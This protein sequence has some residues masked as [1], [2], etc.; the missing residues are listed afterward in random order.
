MSVLIPPVER[1]RTILW[2]MV[3]ES[4]SAHL[5][6][7]I[8]AKY[9][10]RTARTQRCA[11]TL[12]PFTRNVMSLCCPRSCILQT[13][14]TIWQTCAFS[15]DIHRAVFSQIK[16]CKARQVLHLSER[17]LIFRIGD[18]CSDLTCD[19]SSMQIQPQ[20]T[21][22]TLHKMLCLETRFQKSKPNTTRG[23]SPSQDC[24]WTH[25]LRNS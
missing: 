15:V 22:R 12:C 21:C 20:T 17:A 1:A 9:S 4:R 19:A 11:R 2:L 3:T 10:L 8:S 25:L 6:S 24:R 7:S 14:S 23:S 13:D 18:L 16:I 5:F